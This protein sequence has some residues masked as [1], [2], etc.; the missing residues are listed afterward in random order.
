VCSTITTQSFVYRMGDFFGAF[1]RAQVFAIYTLALQ[2][3]VLLIVLAIGMSTSL[4]DATFLFRN[5]AL[6]ARSILARN[7]SMP[8]A[9]ILMLKLFPF[10]PAVAITIAVLAITPFRRSCPDCCSRPEDDPAIS[11]A[12]WFRRLHWRS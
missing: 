2:L 12:C 6:L 4:S 7:V 11:S 3:S 5:P 9:A 8:I 1:D 10:P